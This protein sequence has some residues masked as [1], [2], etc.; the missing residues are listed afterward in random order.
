MFDEHGHDHRRGL[1]G[2]ARRVRR[3][4]CVVA[5]LE[6]KVLGFDAARVADDLHGSGFSGNAEAFHA[7]VATS[8]ALLVDDP[9]EALAYGI[10]S[11]RGEVYLVQNLTGDFEL[12][13]FAV[14]CALFNDAHDVR[15]ED[16]AAICN[17]G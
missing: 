13:Y 3:E 10:Q 4:P 7:S 16:L 12:L 17:R 9:P 8:A 11:S 6:R 2:V 14:R 5:I 1:A 15:L